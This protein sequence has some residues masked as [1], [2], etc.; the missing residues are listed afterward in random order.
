MVANVRLAFHVLQLTLYE[1]ISPI[2][3]L[4]SF[5]IRSPI[6]HAVGSASDH[7]ELFACT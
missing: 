3:V 6:V 5:T 1:W 7:G 4:D 2:P